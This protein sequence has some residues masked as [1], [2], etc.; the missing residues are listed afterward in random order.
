MVSN[1]LCINRQTSDTC[2]DSFGCLQGLLWWNADLALT[3]QLLNE[4]RD[5]SS[6]DRNVFN[7]TADHVSFR[8]FTKRHIQI[9]FTQTL[10]CKYQPIIQCA[11]ILNKALRRLL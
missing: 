8:L 1:K 5:I 6:G 4:E 2:L 11:F 9:T 7:T 3:Q 10:K